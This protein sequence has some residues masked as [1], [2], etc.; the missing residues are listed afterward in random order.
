MKVGVMLPQN[1]AENCILL[2]SLQRE[3]LHLENCSP[4]TNLYQTTNLDQTV[5]LPC[6][7]LSRN[8]NGTTFRFKKRDE[9]GC[10]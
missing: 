9:I 10:F 2:Q 4:I 3:G 1:I 6:E 7:L 5:T 8:K